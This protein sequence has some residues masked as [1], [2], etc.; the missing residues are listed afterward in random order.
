MTNEQVTII[1]GS[2]APTIVAVTGLIVVL[3]KIKDV[4]VMVNSRLTELLD[5]SKKAS[6]AEGE[7]HEKDKTQ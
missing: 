6:F 3:R 7:K 2:I 4:H 1:I 5:V